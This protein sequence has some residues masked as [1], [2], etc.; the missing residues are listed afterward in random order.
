VVD[1]SREVRRLTFDTIQVRYQFPL[2]HC[3]HCPN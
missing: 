1:P 3:T 2:H